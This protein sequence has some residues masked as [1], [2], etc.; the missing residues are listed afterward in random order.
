MQ[1]PTARN[2]KTEDEV[3]GSTFDNGTKRVVIVDAGTLVKA[4][5]DKAS[6]VSSNRVV[7][8]TFDVK[9]LFATD[10]KLVG[11]GRD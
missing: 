3:N 4:R 5:R 10:R 9:N 11:R 8:I 1:K 2:N 7:R 6:F